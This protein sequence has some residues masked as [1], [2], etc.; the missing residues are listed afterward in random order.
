MGRLLRDIGATALAVGVAILAVLLVAACKK[1]GDMPAASTATPAVTQPAPAQP[2]KPAPA[3]A[4][5][6]RGIP[7]NA[8][9]SGPN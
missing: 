3:P 6:V 1:V 2:V 4:A 7:Q 5:T 9:R 8:L